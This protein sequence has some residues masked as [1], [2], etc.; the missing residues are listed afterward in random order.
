MSLL[1][2][3]LASLAVMLACATSVAVAADLYQFI[4]VV[5]G[6]VNPRGPLPAGALPFAAGQTE[7]GSFRYLTCSD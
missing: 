4:G 6:I 3:A 5:S 2:A 1:R 7:T